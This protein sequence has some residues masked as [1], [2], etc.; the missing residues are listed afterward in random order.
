[1]FMGMLPFGSLQ[2]GA[3]A[4]RFGAPAAL[5]LGALICLG[6]GAFVWWRWPHVR[7]L[8]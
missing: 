7:A 6:F 1:M 3:V 4:E 8:P 5:T 2:V